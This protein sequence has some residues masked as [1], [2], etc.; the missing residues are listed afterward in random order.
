MGLNFIWS[1]LIFLFL[2]NLFQKERLNCFCNIWC[3]VS[4][5]CIVKLRLISL[6]ESLGVKNQVRKLHVNLEISKNFN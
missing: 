4:L 2:K 3:L 1:Q 5:L 6:L